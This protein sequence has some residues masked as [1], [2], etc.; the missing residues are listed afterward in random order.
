MGPGTLGVAAAQINLLVN[1]SLATGEQGA[2]SALG[3]AFRLMYMPIGIFGVSVATAAIPDLARQAAAHA[4]ADMRSTLSSGVRLM[5]MLSVPA[6]VGLMV[7]AQPIIELIFQHGEF[8]AAD[9]AKVAGALVFYAP[10][11]IGYSLVKIAS[12]SFYSLQ[13]AR[14]PVIVSLVAIA[15]NLALNLWLHSLMGF[16]GLALGT[17]VAASI[18]AGLLIVLLSRRIDGVDGARVLVSFLKIAAAS[19]VMGAAAYWTEAWLH[20]LLPAE[21]IVPRLVRVGAGIG[22]GVGTLALAA[23]ALRI[24]EFRQAMQRLMARA[25]NIAA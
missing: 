24:D 2:V 7:L 25:R 17:S 12:P 10:G 19:V 20:E 23:W 18:N 3:Y 1:T 4:Y 11:V 14:T 9:T 21:A 22:A 5:L 16:R 6:A 13:D 15:S 8:T